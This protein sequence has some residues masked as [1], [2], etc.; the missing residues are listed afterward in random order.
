MS[1]NF[2]QQTVR[3]CNATLEI[4]IFRRVS[5]LVKLNRELKKLN[6]ST[7]NNNFVIY[8]DRTQKVR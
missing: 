1:K 8:S 6:G 5:K 2:K 4:Q 3:R 7:L